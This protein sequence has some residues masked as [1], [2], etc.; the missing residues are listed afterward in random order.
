MFLTE[1]FHK[2]DSKD[3]HDTNPNGYSMVTM[4]GDVTDSQTDIDGDMKTLMYRSQDPPK[5]HMIQ[6]TWR[7]NTQ[8]KLVTMVK[9]MMDRRVLLATSLY[10]LLGFAGIIINEVHCV[11][12]CIM[13][14]TS[15]S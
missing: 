3:K 13:N 4:N 6:K 11:V 1:T 12:V 9:L 5:H 10:G 15:G 7:K 14:H 8:N 2:S